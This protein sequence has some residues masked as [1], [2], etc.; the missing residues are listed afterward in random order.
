M[1]K[2]YILASLL[3]I[4]MGVKAQSIG[5]QTFSRV[6]GTPFKNFSF[7][8]SAVVDVDNDGYQDLVLTGGVDTDNDGNQNVSK[9]Y[10]YKNKG[11]VYQEGIELDNPVSGA[12][13][14]AFDN[15]NDGFKDLITIGK[16]I[17]DWQDPKQYFYKNENGSFVFKKSVENGKKTGTGSAEFFDFDHDGLLDY[18]TNGDIRYDAKFNYYKNAGKGEFYEIP[19][20]MNIIPT[21]YGNFKFVDLNNDNELDMIISGVSPVTFEPIMEIYLNEKGKF[22]KVQ[23]TLPAVERSTIG[24]ADFDNDGDLDFVINGHRDY[25]PQLY[26][27]WNDGTG[28]FTKQDVG[29]GVTTINAG[30]TIDTG[31]LNN[32][33]YPDFI[34][35][36]NL[37]DSLENAKYTTDIYTY[38]PTTKKFNKMIDHNIPSYGGS[39]DVRLVDYDN[40]NTLDVLVSG[41]DLSITG[42]PFITKLYKNNLNV[43]NQ[44]PTAPTTLKHQVRDTDVFFSWE[45]ATDD[46]TSVLGLTYEISVGTAENKADIAKYVVTTNNWYLK[47][48]KLPEKFYWSVRAIDASHI[49]SDPSTV[50]T[51]KLATHE[52]EWAKANVYP[53]PAVDKITIGGQDTIKSVSIVDLSG[54]VVATQFIGRD[55]PVAHLPKGVYILKVELG[56]N[57]N[58]TKKIIKQ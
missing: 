27:F 53:N 35:V 9:S 12:Y 21:S 49:Y 58:F 34:V 23:Q 57:K 37:T 24:V 19:S 38:N 10:L 46:K 30:N 20:F 41:M 1:R 56:N 43:V 18:A 15:D 32:D 51:A 6:D 2:I 25:V 55:I 33:G 48:E 11:G 17:G 4:V 29:D 7:Q 54:K 47:K 39:P 31:D 5:S 52:T 40:D 50:Q 8:G 28:H 36:G 42:G 22:V 44:K 13:V 14:L 3:S 16:K 26:V 45:G